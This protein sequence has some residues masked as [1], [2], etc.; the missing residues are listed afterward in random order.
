MVILY[1][2]GQGALAK[3]R[4]GVA[5]STCAPDGLELVGKTKGRV[6]STLTL[7]ANSVGG[8]TK[9]KSF[10]RPQ[11]LSLIRLADRHSHFGAATL[12]GPEGRELRL[13]PIRVNDRAL[14]H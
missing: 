6:T 1:A 13:T 14:D 11:I 4:A 3:E 7:C 10:R 5:I 2:R 12:A 8:R 9:M